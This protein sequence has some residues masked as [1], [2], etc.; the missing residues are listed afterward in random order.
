MEKSSPAA[1]WAKPGMSGRRRVTANAI[2]LDDG[3]GLGHARTQGEGNGLA[4]IA[5]RRFFAR[6]LARRGQQKA[7]SEKGACR[8]G[9]FPIPTQTAISF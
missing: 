5:R 1:A 2:L 9:E 7:E 6:R 4:G 3:A 8:N